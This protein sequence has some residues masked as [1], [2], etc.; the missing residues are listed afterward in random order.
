MYSKSSMTKSM[1]VVAAFVAGISGV[2][3]AADNSATARN[4]AIQN[5]YLQDESI[6][7]PVGSSPADRSAAPADP[8]PKAST[9]GGETARFR[10]MDQQL[11]AESTNTPVDSPSVN[12]NSVNA[13]PAPNAMAEERFL[14]QNA[15]K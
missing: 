5:E 14:E 1:V 8:I 13:D 7:M 9:L 4:F 2:A 6:S 12:K 11:Q 15:T 10:V 3:H